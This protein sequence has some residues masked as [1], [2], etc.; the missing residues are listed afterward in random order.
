MTQS[1]VDVDFLNGLQLMID[2]MAASHL[3]KSDDDKDYDEAYGDLQEPY[4]AKLGSETM[5]VRRTNSGLGLKRTDQNA[6]G[7]PESRRV[8][9]K[10]GTMTAADEEEQE[11][12]DNR[13]VASTDWESTSDLP[14]ADHWCPDVQAWH[15]SDHEPAKA[16]SVHVNVDSKEGDDPYQSENGEVEKAGSVK[17]QH[18]DMATGTDPLPGHRGPGKRAIGKEY[19]QNT[20][21]DRHNQ[22]NS[23]DS[24]A[25]PFLHRREVNEDEEEENE[26]ID[27]QWD[28]EEHEQEAGENIDMALPNLMKILTGENMLLRIQIHMRMMKLQILQ[29]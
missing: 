25:E 15:T 22:E 29:M 9:Q 1:D 20:N 24:I 18:V 19:D 10:H 14:D 4:D 2:S 8:P 27:K 5:G 16:P 11:I 3:E 17:E 12:E 28:A 21:L 13:E 6:S 7:A 23:E 26:D